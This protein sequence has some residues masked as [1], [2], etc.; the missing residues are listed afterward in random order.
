MA[1]R[2]AANQRE[3]HA[4]R[5]RVVDVRHLACC[6]SVAVLAVGKAEEASK[7]E[8]QIQ[9]RVHGEED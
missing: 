1:V 9:H 8:I 7:Q 6:G 5:A 3:R 4:W 2:R